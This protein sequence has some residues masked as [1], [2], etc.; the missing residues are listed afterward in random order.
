MTQN[1]K[2]WGTGK[3]KITLISLNF[4]KLF[5][6]SHKHGFTSISV[7]QTDCSFSSTSKDAHKDQRV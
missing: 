6:D 1:Y 4:G 7:H 3:G 2:L 5:H